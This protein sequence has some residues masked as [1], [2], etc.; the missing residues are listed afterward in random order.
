MPTTV[1]HR[2]FYRG[3]EG[4]VLGGVA[5]GLAAH[6]SVP[7]RNARI[8]LVVLCLAG[9]VGVLLYGAFWVFVP[10][11]EGVLGSRPGPAV[12]QNPIEMVAIG[13]VT[14]VGYIVLSN[15]GFLPGGSS[16][17]P[18]ILAVIGAALVW[19]QADDSQRRRWRAVTEGR[20]G[21]MLRNAAGALLVVAGLFGFLAARGDLGAARKGIVATI[22]VVAGVAVL[23][24]PWWLRLTSD[25]TLERRERIRSE[26]RAEVAAHIH[27]SVLQTL[28]LIQ[29]SATKPTEVRRLA[30][31]QERELRSWLYRPDARGTLVAALEQNAAE[32][33]EDFGVPV[34]VVAVGDCQQDAGLAALCAAAREAIVNAAKHSG[35]S[36]VSVYAEVEPTSVAVFVRDRG[37]GFDQEAVPPDRFGLAESVSG[38]MER[39]GGSVTIKSE[40]GEGTEVRLEMPRG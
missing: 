21:G 33:E 32:V 35:A 9:G 31:S 34:E 40:P 20:R 2:R 7:V 18:L 39:H 37:S 27:D 29:K 17:I 23:T 5:V 28:T 15:I 12:R 24:A 26:E 11:Q 8:A 13:A 19:R 14:I 30:R 1:E 38:R 16:S 4:K 22:V 6:F 36:V 3:T 25:L 10:Q